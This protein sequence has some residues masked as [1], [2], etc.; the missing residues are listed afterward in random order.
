MVQAEQYIYDNIVS[1]EPIS[2]NLLQDDCPTCPNLI[3]LKGSIKTSL[4]D[5]FIVGEHNIKT[6]KTT[7]KSAKVKKSKN[8]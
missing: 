4:G 1:E 8:R 2:D 5:I 7:F 3:D 6:G